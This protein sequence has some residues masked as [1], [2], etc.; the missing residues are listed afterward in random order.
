MKPP[1]RVKWLFDVER[2]KTAAKHINGYLMD[3]PDV[4]VESRRTAFC[5]KP[6][7]FG[8]MPNDG[9]Y[10]S[11]YDDDAKN[12]IT[13][14]YPQVCELFRRLVGSQESINNISRWCLWLK[15]VSPKVMRS[16]PPV[17]EAVEKVRQ[18]RFASKREATHKLAETPHLFGEIRQPESGQYLLI[19]SVSSEKRQYVPMSFLSADIIANNLALIVPNATLYHFGVLTSSVHMA[20]MRMVCGRLEMRYRYSAAI[21]YN[22]FPWPDGVPGGHALPSRNVSE[23]SDESELVKRQI[24]KTAQ[25]I[26]DARALY[27]DSSLADLY[28]PLTMPPELRKAHA[29]NDAAVMKAYGWPTDL[30]ES[31]IVSRLFAMY[32]TLAKE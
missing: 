3:G 13:A 28:D 21:V 29:A 11:D 32:A 27:P 17:M 8:S 26:L 7:V 20:W 23:A 4:F 24:E 1:Q 25:G 2:G 12:A 10:L 31:E 22:N 14:K 6:L 5:D 30:S 16:I 18:M 19:P 9:G 15:G